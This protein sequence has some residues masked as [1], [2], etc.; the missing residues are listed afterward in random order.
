MGGM[1][2]SETGGLGWGWGH[3]G[4]VVGMGMVMFSNAGFFG[5]LGGMEGLLVG[6]WLFV[7]SMYLVD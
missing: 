7:C 5:D 6:V 2:S 4:I 3:A 1:C